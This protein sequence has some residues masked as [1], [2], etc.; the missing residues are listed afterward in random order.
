MLC[1]SLLLLSFVIQL[2]HL[3]KSERLIARLEILSSILADNED[4]EK[5]CNFQRKLNNLLE[6]KGWFAFSSRSAYGSVLDRCLIS[7]C[8]IGPAPLVFDHN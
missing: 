7:V 6:S 4:K 1:V 5:M 3:S 2:Q 8:I